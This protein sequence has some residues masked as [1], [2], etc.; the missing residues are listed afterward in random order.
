RRAHSG[1]HCGRPRDE[2][3]AET[4]GARRRDPRAPARAHVLRAHD[5]WRHGLRRAPVRARQRGARHPAAALA[6]HGR[7]AV[8]VR[9]ARR[10]APAGRARHPEMSAAFLAIFLLTALCVG[11]PIAIALGLASIATLLLFA[12]QSLA[13]LAQRFF[14][15]AQTPALLAIPFFIL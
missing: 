4:D 2:P 10:A 15:A 13:V 8:R 1:A 12:D 5:L 3:S 14:S 6:A 11:V 9:A 7:D